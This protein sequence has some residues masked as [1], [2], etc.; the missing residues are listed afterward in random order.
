MNNAVY[1]KTIENLRNRIN[2]KLVNNTK[3]NWKWTSKP[4]Y[5][6]QKVFYNDLVTIRQNKVTLSPKN[7]LGLT[8]VGMCILDLSKVLMYEF[9]YDYIK[10]KQ[11]NNSR[12]LFTD[13]DSL[14]YEIKPEDVYEDFSKI[15]KCL[16]LAM[17]QLTQNIMIIQRN[18]FLVKWK[19]K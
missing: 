10:N 3:D 19:I 13:N 14:M 2:V 11:W 1:V 15:E 4:S 6:S 12:L 8:Y 7:M 9:H 18:W 16:V 17:I 5:L